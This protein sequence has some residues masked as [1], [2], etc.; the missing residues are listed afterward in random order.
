VFGLLVNPNVVTSEHQ[1]AVTQEAARTKGVRL[2]IL[3]AGTQ[4][5]IDAAF[6]E[7]AKLHANALVVGDDALFYHQRDQFAALA[8]RY[9]L[10]AIYAL[11]EYV[12]A[13]GLMSYGANLVAAYRQSAAYVTRVLAGAK[14][15]GDQ[16]QDGE[17]ARHHGA[18]VAS[19]PRW[20]GN[21]VK[22]FI[23]H[24]PIACAQ[25]RNWHEP[26]EFGGAAIPTAIGGATDAPGAIASRAPVHFPAGGTGGAAIGALVG[27]VHSGIPRS[28]LKA[29]ADLLDASE[30][31]LIVVYE[32][33]LADQVKRN[34]KAIKQIVRQ[35]VDVK[36]DQ[37]ADEMRQAHAA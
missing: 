5:E 34:I 9:S 21:R 18:T 10:P 37:I 8:A 13:G 7:L 22:T 14:P 23:R 12:V 36:A 20:P 31:A 19:R 4:G 28:D 32:T 16:S 26:K 2:H 11:G 29:I 35:M 24:T 1:I 6:L 17:G 3:K 33:K 25:G 30:A 27:H 15:A